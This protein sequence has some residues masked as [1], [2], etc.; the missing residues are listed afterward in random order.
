MQF[1]SGFPDFRKSGLEIWLAI[2][3]SWHPHL[4]NKTRPDLESIDFIMAGEW[5]DLVSPLVAAYSGDFPEGCTKE[6][7]E[8]TVSSVLGVKIPLIESSIDE[9]DE[10]DI[11]SIK[12]VEELE[13]VF[14]KSKALA[15]M[16]QI[17]LCWKRIY[18]MICKRLKFAEK[19]LFPKRMKC[20]YPYDPC[21][22]DS[23]NVSAGKIF[24]GV[25]W[26][27]YGKQNEEPGRI[28]EMHV[29]E[30]VYLYGVASDLAFYG[31]PEIVNV[32]SRSELQLFVDSC[33][34]DKDFGKFAASEACAE[35]LGK[36]SCWCCDYLFSFSGLTDSLVAGAK[37][38]IFEGSIKTEYSYF[39]VK[40]KV[41]NTVAKYLS[42]KAVRSSFLNVSQR[43]RVLCGPFGVVDKSCVASCGEMNSVMDSAMVQVANAIGL[44]ID[45]CPSD[46]PDQDNLPE[47]KRAC[48]S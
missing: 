7:I 24:E 39:D 16:L 3:Q 43:A 32:R 10:D 22:S 9:D 1:G 44:I 28:V 46:A 15:T 36:N 40:R 31:F 48:M 23:L 27:I 29:Y 30:F 38:S 21:D 41:L 20:V 11:Y 45:P 25:M 35:C 13:H 42:A 33:L 18:K 12:S 26:M 37:N 47:V 34:K 17:S 4:P 6:E 14:L 8:V 5:F 2:V 19:I